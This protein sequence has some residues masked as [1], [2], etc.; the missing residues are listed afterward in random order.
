MKRRLSTRSAECRQLQRVVRVLPA[1]NDNGL[2][3]R[4][5]RFHGL[6]PATSRVADRVTELDFGVRIELA[7]SLG[8]FAGQI[9]GKRRL[10]D[11]AQP[12]MRKDSNVVYLTD[13]VIRFEIFDNPLNFDVSGFAEHDDVKAGAREFLC[14]LVDSPDERAGCVDQPFVCRQQ[15]LPATVANAVRGD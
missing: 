3:L 15:L 6:L 9:W 10:A 5:K 2:N 13:D 8:E 14:R 1:N 12:A 11:N 7:N 4:E